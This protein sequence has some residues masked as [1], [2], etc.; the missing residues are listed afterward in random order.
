MNER[1][2]RWVVVV[3]LAATVALLGVIAYRV[4]RGGVPTYQWSL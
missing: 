3:L 1:A 4:S 2:F